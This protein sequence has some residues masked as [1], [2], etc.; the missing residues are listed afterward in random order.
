[1]A[2]NANRLYLLNQG[3]GRGVRNWGYYTADSLATVLGS[4][5][6]SDGVKQGLK[7]GDVID[8]FVGT[9]NSPVATTPS[10]AAA[11]DLSEFSALTDYARCQVSATNST[12]FAATVVAQAPDVAPTTN[13]LF[14]LWGATASTQPTSSNQADVLSTAAMSSAATN[15]GWLYATSTQADGIVRLLRQIRADLVAVGNIKGS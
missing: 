2:Y 6:F 13:S 5:Y 12:T 10:T 15:G 3:I 9:L 4:G 1:M 11:G 8:V 14:S 7:L